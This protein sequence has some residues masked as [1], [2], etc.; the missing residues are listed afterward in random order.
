MR[1]INL[2]NI[3][4]K[5]EVIIIKKN[6]KLIFRGLINHL[7]FLGEEILYAKVKKIGKD[8]NIFEIV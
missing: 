3:F 7:V 4:K 6:G 1:V 8:N 5:N 2:S